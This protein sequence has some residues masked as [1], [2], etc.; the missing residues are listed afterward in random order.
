MT[1]PVKPFANNFKGNNKN[2]V[3]ANQFIRVPEVR[4]IADNGDQLGVLKT[5][6]AL[7]KAEEAGLDLVEVAPNVTPPVCRL[8]DLGKYLYSL[9]KKEKAARKNQKTV[10][11]KEVKM[12]CKIEDHDYQTKL[13]NARKFIERGDKVKLTLTF[14]GREITHRDIGEKL[15][16]RFI[17]DL[18]DVGAV[19][20]NEGLEGRSIQVYFAPS[21]M[22]GKSKKK[23]SSKEEAENHAKVENE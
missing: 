18:S 22:L 17:E 3:R 5:E 4:L 21:S 11:I 23:D 15:I 20:R 7:A 10:N 1:K 12:G 6:D 2:R 13:R 8:M 14:R 9:D 16:A 19:E